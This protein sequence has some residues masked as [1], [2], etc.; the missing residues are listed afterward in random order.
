MSTRVGCLRPPSRVFLLPLLY[1]WTV[2]VSNPS[3]LGRGR[4]DMDSQVQTS[5]LLRA[6]DLFEESQFLVCEGL[7]QMTLTSFPSPCRNSETFG[8]LSPVSMV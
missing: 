1:T 2:A 3:P 4:R 7:D 8:S 6:V 5:A